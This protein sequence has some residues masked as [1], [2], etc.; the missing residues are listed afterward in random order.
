[1]TCGAE[2]RMSCWRKSNWKNAGN[3]VGS[4]KC[5][6][7]MPAGSASHFRCWMKVAD[8]TNAAKT[9]SCVL[10]SRITRKTFG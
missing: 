3:S 9:W 7:V 8:G 10:Y 6:W 2:P 1:M 4:S 5:F